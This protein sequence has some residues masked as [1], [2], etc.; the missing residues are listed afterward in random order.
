[1]IVQD[2]DVFHSLRQKG[3][4]YALRNFFRR[5]PGDGTPKHMAELLNEL[6][7]DFLKRDLPAKKSLKRS[8]SFMKYTTRNDTIK[9]VQIGVDVQC[10]P[11][12]RN[13]A[14]YFDADSRYFFPFDPN[15]GKAFFAL[16]FNAVL[17][18]RLDDDLFQTP[19][20]AMDIGKVVVEIQ[21]RIADDLTGPVVGYITTP[22]NMKNLNTATPEFFL[23]S[24]KMV[25]VSPFS[26][27]VHVLMLGQKENI[28]HGPRLTELKELSLQLPGLRVASLA[29]IDDDELIHRAS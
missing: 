11:M 16:R 18:Q 5:T 28:S 22:I 23:T 6:R 9:V 26:N 24:K 2:T 3:W 14:A 20:I 7:L 13:P 4:C 1:M 27:R 21:N 8:N 29:D 15:A 17:Q 12:H 25:W 10:K 19:E